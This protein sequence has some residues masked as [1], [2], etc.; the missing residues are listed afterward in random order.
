MPRL[1]AFLV[2]AVLT[3]P[4]IADVPVATILCYHEVHAPGDTVSRE[5]RR[6]AA[7]NDTSE[8]MR[9]VATLDNF[10]AQLDYLQTNGYHV[11]PLSD[12]V[13]YLAGRV[14]VLPPRAVVITFDDGWL[15]TF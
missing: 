7:T 15:C 6:R 9:Y 3:L 8:Q 4:A 10:V 2:A 11:I 13:D 1:C 12:L 5:P 14:D